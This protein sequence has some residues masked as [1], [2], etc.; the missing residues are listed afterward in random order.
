MIKSLARIILCVGWCFET[1]VI[2]SWIY[3]MSCMLFRWMACMLFMMSIGVS[4]LF[5]IF[6]TCNNESP[7]SLTQQTIWFVEWE[8]PTN[9]NRHIDTILDTKNG[10]LYMSILLIWSMLILK[11]CHGHTCPW[12]SFVKGLQVVLN[13]IWFWFWFLQKFCVTKTHHHHHHMSLHYL[14]SI[15]RM[16]FISL[17]WEP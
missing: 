2:W 13:S 4:G 7:N 16:W 5:A 12:S 8:V 11:C 1:I 15:G 6:R 14:S 10:L 9:Y 17:R 3:G